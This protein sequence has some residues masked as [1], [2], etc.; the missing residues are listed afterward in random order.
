MYTYLTD[1]VIN[2]QK[3][4]KLIIFD[5]YNSK[6]DNKIKKIGKTCHLDKN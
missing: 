1:Y 4:K 5:Y 3:R 6:R 2:I